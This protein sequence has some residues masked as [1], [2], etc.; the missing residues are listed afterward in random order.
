[1]N[2]QTAQTSAH[3]TI[4]TYVLGYALSVVCT[5]VAFGL[6][7]WHMQTHHT[8]PSHE[9]IYASLMA[10]AIA[11][12]FVQVIFFL[13]LGRGSSAR[14]NVIVFCFALFIVISFV[15]GSLWI[16]K[17]LRHNTMQNMYIGGVISPETQ[18]N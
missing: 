16:M 18:A 5:L 17:N 6:V 8:F 14:W 7:A 10:L 11:Q 12:L 3:G 2:M 1:M 4:R 15:G 9:M 13:H